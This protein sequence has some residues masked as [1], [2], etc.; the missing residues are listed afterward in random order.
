MIFTSYEESS[1][2]NKIN[3]TANLYAIPANLNM[4]VDA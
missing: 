1:G 3:I 4:E 2:L